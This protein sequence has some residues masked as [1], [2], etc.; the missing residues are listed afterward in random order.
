MQVET[1]IKLHQGH[2]GIQHCRL[3]TNMSVWWPGISHQIYDFVSQ[4]S[5][6]CRDAPPRREPLIPS[7]LP[8]FPWQ[9][10]ATD[11]FQLDGIT[12]LVVVEYFSHFPEVILLKSTTSFSVINA[13]KTIFAWHDIPEELVSD[14]GSQFNSNKFADFAATYGFNHITSS[15]HY[16]QGNGQA[17]RM[18]KTVKKLL[19]RLFGSTR[20]SDDTTTMVW[21]ISS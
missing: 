11:L 18:V 2:H 17:E 16:P 19:K 6:C 5:E 8:D 12:Y 15:P 7:L 3:R 13:P 1:L 4:C 9:K 21:A 14:N 10:A 20:I